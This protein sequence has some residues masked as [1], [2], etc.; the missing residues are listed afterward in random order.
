MISHI[1]GQIEAYKAIAS[2]GGSH[3]PRFAEHPE[4]D[5]L[6]GDKQRALTKVI[7]ELELNYTWIG[8]GEKK[9][10]TNGVFHFMH[11]W[12][13]SAL[14]FLLDFSLIAN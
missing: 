5:P 8:S 13:C 11:W 7:Q 4:P 3:H 2:T 1:A 10:R 6:N 12:R 14:A 9:N